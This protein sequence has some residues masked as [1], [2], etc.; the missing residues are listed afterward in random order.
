MSADTRSWRD[1]RWVLHASSWAVLVLMALASVTAGALGKRI[2]DTQQDRLVAERAGEVAAVLGATFGASASQFS[3]LGSIAT[4]PQAN[5]AAFAAAARPILAAAAKTVGIVDRHDGSFVVRAAVGDGPAVGETLSS[6]RAALAARSLTTSGM[7]TAVSATASQ[8]RLILASAANPTTIVYL[9]YAFTPGQVV[10]V[11]KN[12]PFRG[13]DVSL[14]ASRRATPSAL[15]IT[16]HKGGPRGTVDRRLIDI[17]AERWLML[18]G[19]RRSL[20]TPLTRQFPRIL[21]LVGL[22]ATILLTALVEVLARRRSYALALVAERTAGLRAAQQA[23]EA[24]NHSKS[25]FLSRMSHELRTP[26]N[27]V[28][29][30]GQI[31][32]LRDL[33][34]DQSEAVQQILKGGR[35]LLGLINEVLD[36]SQI[37]SGGLA[38]S[39]EPVL[40]SELVGEAIDLVRPLAAERTINLTGASTGC[41]VY[42]L[43]DRQ[44]A[45]QILLNLLSNAIKYNRA[46]GSVAIDCADGESGCLRI[47]VRDT[48]M[49]ISPDRLDQLFVPFER[50]GADQTDIPGTGIGLALSQRLAEAMGG[51]I[52]VDTTV[53]KGSTF[54]LELPL[55]EGP[56]E[57][58]ERLD[59]PAAVAITP[60]GATPHSVVLYI[61]DNLSNVKLVERVLAER[62]DV[63]VIAAM[64][65]RLGV[66]LAHEHRPV[67][68]LLDLHLPDIGGD[69]VLQQLRDDPRTASIPVVIVSADATPGQ[70]KRLTAAGARAFLTKP[71]DVR[72]LLA[73]FDEAAA[74]ANRTLDVDPS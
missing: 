2:D 24:A 55:V 10:P 26:L 60:D 71:L 53:G 11:Q 17:G 49:G 59:A 31:L 43:A 74:A 47:N 34:A 23:A 45:K 3:V 72:G 35:H 21:L 8:S 40:A 5:A 42:V 13:L 58:Y 32:E 56:V 61:E 54:T 62:P 18:T 38:I 25:V 30:F 1:R 51:R 66:E 70:M 48:G 68:I 7:V 28:L 29:G 15:V 44:R 41:N 16:T 37:E 63:E 27:A 36:I 9:E 14:Y 19:S 20:T 65:G 22:L 64:Q 46:R 52:L 12:S 4:D 39:P 57:R 50:L 67:L 69:V 73:V 33:D 6:D